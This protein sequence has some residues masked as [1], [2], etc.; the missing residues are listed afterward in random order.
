[1]NDTRTRPSLFQWVRAYIALINGFKS[2]VFINSEVQWFRSQVAAQSGPSAPKIFQNW[3]FT[4]IMLKF[5]KSCSRSRVA[6][7]PI[8]FG[9]SHPFPA[10]WCCVMRVSTDSRHTAAAHCFGNPISGVGPVVQQ[11][12]HSSRWSAQQGHHR[13]SNEHRHKKGAPSQTGAYFVKGV[14]K[15]LGS[16]HCFGHWAHTL[17]QPHPLSATRATSPLLPSEM[18]HE[19]L[20]V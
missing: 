18:R 3:D 9:K 19:P 16:A 10:C 7:N 13:L 5:R 15:S 20:V 17:Q 11:R 14:T 8:I 2:V 12:Q 1:M 6:S 4:L